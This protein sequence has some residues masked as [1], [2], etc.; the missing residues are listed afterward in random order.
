I[1]AT[2]T[3]TSTLELANS[4][5]I[6]DSAEIANRNT[7]SV[8]ELLKNDYG[9]SFTSQGGPGTLSNIY[10]RGGSASY[11]HVLIDGVELNLTSDPNGVYDFAALSS[12]S[13]ER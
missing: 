10:L 2:K 11:T 8:F 9:L 7:S 1:S 12:E 5:S 13:I 6:I 3:N 4:I